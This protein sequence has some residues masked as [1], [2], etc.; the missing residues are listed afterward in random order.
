[1]A[2][3]YINTSECEKYFYKHLDDN[4]MIGAMNAI[5]EMP[6]ADVQPVKRGKWLKRTSTPDSLKC[7]KCGNSHEY[8]TTFC[9]NCGARMDGDAE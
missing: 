1:M 7:S 3:K 8:E 2:D 4:G 6:A 5:D 9:P